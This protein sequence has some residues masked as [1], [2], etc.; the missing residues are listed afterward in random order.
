MHVCGVTE[1]LLLAHG[2]TTSLVEEFRAAPPDTGHCDTGAVS[3]SKSTMSCTDTDDTDTATRQCVA[4]A[5]RRRIAKHCENMRT[6]SQLSGSMTETEERM[7]QHQQVVVGTDSAG[8]AGFVSPTTE[9]SGMY[10]HLEVLESV[11]TRSYGSVTS[12]C[13]QAGRARS[14]K[15]RGDRR[16]RGEL[17]PL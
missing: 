5:S 3:T 11:R 17:Y 7:V 14:R 16:L 13:S 4:A 15:H 10:Q 2:Q 6:E 9:S 12:W 1:S 8:W